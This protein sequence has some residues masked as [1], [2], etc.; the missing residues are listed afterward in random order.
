MRSPN[1]CVLVA[2]HASADA[3]WR[4]TFIAS[5]KGESGSDEYGLSEKAMTGLTSTILLLPAN[6]RSRNEY[7]SIDARKLLCSHSMG[8]YHCAVCC[9]RPNRS[10]NARPNSRALPLRFG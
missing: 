4:D 3:R 1:I 5:M 2:H 7:P 9:A 10:G 8:G 6:L